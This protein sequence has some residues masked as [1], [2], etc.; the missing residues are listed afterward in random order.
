MEQPFE[1]EAEDEKE[2]EDE[3][4]ENLTEAGEKVQQVSPKTPSRRVQ[5][6]HPSD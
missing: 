2:V 4:E 5:K 3:D 6:N 1:E